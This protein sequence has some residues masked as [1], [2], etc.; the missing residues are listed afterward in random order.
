MLGKIRAG[1]SILIHAGSG[2]IGQAAI[3]ISSYYGLKIFTT[4]GTEEKREF[5]KNKW[6]HIKGTKLLICVYPCKDN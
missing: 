2:G 4:V 6:P 5:I 1:Q 3:N